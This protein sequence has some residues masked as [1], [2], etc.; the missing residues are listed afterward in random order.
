MPHWIVLQRLAS[1]SVS[2]P[3]KIAIYQLI[4]C[5]KKE[6]D[7]RRASTGA[8]ETSLEVFSVRRWKR[9][10]RGMKS[11]VWRCAIA[12]KTDVSSWSRV[13]HLSMFNENAP[14]AAG[15]LRLAAVTYRVAAVLARRLQTLIGHPTRDWST[16]ILTAN[17]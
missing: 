16:T 1:F 3:F 17:R 8:C 11:F 14:K 7:V 4:E 9:S 10:L 13:Y 2:R 6:I 5:S 15:E 12:L